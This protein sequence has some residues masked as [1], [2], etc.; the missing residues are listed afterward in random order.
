MRYL[1]AHP[2]HLL[3]QQGALL[4][5]LRTRPLFTVMGRRQRQT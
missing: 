2:D 4:L 5:L 1:L 3:L